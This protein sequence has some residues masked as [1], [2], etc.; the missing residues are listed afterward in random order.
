[1]RGPDAR[2]RSRM[3]LCASPS[4][5]VLSPHILLRSGHCLS[6]YPA[7]SMGADEANAFP[8]YL[9]VER[10]VSALTQNQ[11]LSALLFLYREVLG[12][13]LPWLDD[14]I[15]AQRPPCAARERAGSVGGT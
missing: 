11:A 1:M 6:E 9:A 5:E 7:A 14:L 13:P 12:E 8:T 10:T 15:R 3:T 4:A 2:S